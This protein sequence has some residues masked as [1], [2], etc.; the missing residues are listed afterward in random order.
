TQGS[1]SEDFRRVSAGAEQAWLRSYGQGGGPKVSVL[2]RIDP[3][4][5]QMLSAAYLSA[6]LGNGDSNSLTVTGLA[7]NSSG[8]LVVS[9]QSFFAPRRPNGQAMTQLTSGSS[10]FAYTVEI[11]PDLRRVVSTAAVGWS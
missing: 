11:T 6:L 4:T 7:V 9:A 1:A 2:G 8:N 5:G 10:P 3:A